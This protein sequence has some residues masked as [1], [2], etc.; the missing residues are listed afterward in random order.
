MSPWT[1]LALTGPSLHERADDDP[2]LTT[3]MLAKASA[4][5]RRGHDAR[6]PRL[7]PLY[8]S[9]VGLPP[10]QLHVGTSEILLDDTRRYAERARA[11]GVDATAHVWEG[12]THVFPSS[13]GLL[14]AAERALDAMAEFLQDK[15]SARRSG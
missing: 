1:D 11:M 12:M 10:I 2:L 5:Y 4:S 9:L 14:D 8:G 15:L 6:D 13:V 3:E 7:S